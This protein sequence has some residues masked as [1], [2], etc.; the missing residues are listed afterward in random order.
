MDPI[1]RS[2]QDAVIVRNVVARARS[3]MEFPSEKAR[4]NYLREHPD[5]DPSNHTVKKNQGGAG[6]EET[7]GKPPIKQM[8]QDTKRLSDT[9]TKMSDQLGK[10]QKS[11]DTA[12]HSKGGA[13]RAKTL[14]DK[15]NNAYSHAVMS[16]ETSFTHA[17]SAINIAR[18]HGASEDE[19][20]RVESILE[21]A[22]KAVAGS[23]KDGYDK[24]IEGKFGEGFAVKVKVENVGEIEKLVGALQNSIQ[25]L[26]NG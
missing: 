6:K 19:I 12:V 21:D 13:E 8:V 25:L 18:K 15:I 10:L 22:R 11:F 7:G 9:V 4:K 20:G 5:A 24:P 26:A 23:K 14:G 16:A 1:L 17:E 3:A 2:F